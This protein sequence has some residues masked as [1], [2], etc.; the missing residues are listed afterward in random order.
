MVCEPV[1][2]PVP[3]V[4]IS[5]GADAVE[6]LYP[7]S[8]FISINLHPQYASYSLVTIMGKSITKVI[9]KPDP[10]ASDVFVVVVNPVEV[11]MIVKATK[12]PA[13]IELV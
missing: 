8:L 4:N 1:T 9:Y 13:H 7:L 5:A 12:S 3:R 6:S 2:S 11:R 10:N